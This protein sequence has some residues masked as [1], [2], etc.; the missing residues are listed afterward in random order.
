MELHGPCF[1]TVWE[2]IKILRSDNGKN[3]ICI[4]N[5]F[6]E[7]GIVY[8]TSCVGTPQQNGR[9]ERKHF[10]ILKVARALLCQADMLIDFWDETILTAALT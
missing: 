1:A 7:L 8:Q 4:G 2:N 6:R 9:V 10:H 5:Q 3:F